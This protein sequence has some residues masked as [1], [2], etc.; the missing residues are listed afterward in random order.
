MDN[1]KWNRSIKSIGKERK[2][3]GKK[4]CRRKKMRVV[5]V[6][7]ILWR[8]RMGGDVSMTRRW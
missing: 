6:V 8:N 2:M 7:T 3:A 1:K 5:N 4:R